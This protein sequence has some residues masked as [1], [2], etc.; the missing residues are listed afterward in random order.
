MNLPTNPL[1]PWRVSASL[2]PHCLAP[3]KP[4][5]CAGIL[6]V[7][8]S[9]R[10]ACSRNARSALKGNCRT[11]GKTYTRLRWRPKSAQAALTVWQHTPDGAERCFSVFVDSD[12]PE[13]THQEVQATAREAASQ[14]LSLPWEL[15]NDGRSYLFQGSRAVRVRRRLPN[16]QHQPV[17]PTRLPIRI[18]LVSPRPEDER[19]GYID[20]R[21]SAK[22]LMDAVDNL[23][24]L[25]TLT[26]LAPPTFPALQQALQRAR[27]ASQPFDVVHFDGHGVYD[28]EHGL[29]GLCFEDPKDAQKLEQ[30]AMQFIH[31]EKLA[32]VMRDYRIPLVFLEA[33]Q[34]AKAEEDPTA[35]VAAKLLDE[36]VASVVAMSHSVLVETAHRFVKAFYSEL[37]RGTRVGTAM[38]AGQQALYGNTWFVPRNFLKKVKL[39]LPSRIRVLVVFIADFHG[40]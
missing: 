29:G 10:P 3:L 2:S 18:L 38:L 40:G 5:I 21:I 8:T 27:E 28:R 37:A 33:C 35:S 34:S 31:A 15:L 25:A 22:P 13:G 17:L 30:R 26:V 7:I 32:G 19:T 36:G 4:M 6:K 9:G 23:G 24:D 20:H 16:R 1:V 12:L 14:L 39:R 11:G